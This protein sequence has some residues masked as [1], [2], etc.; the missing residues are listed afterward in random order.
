M[1]QVN[2]TLDRLADKEAASTTAANHQSNRTIDVLNR[3]TDTINDLNTNV[4]KLGDQ[5]EL[6]RR[7]CIC[8]TPAYPDPASRDLR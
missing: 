3:A 8:Q 6:E 1:G 4:R 2:A 7:H 5:F